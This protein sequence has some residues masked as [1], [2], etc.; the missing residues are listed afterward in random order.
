[1]NRKGNAMRLFATR[2]FIMGGMLFVSGW[3]GLTVPSWA[4]TQT[5]SFSNNITVDPSTG[6]ASAIIPLFTPEG[7]RGIAPS[8]N[9]SYSSLSGSGPFGNGWSMD[10]G[11]ITRSTRKGV[12]AYSPNDTFLC[13]LGGKIYE[14]VKVG[15]NEYRAR[16]E[17]DRLKFI[18]TGNYWVVQDPKGVSYFFGSR[19]GSNIENN[20]RVFKWRLDKVT[21][22]LNNLYVIDYHSDGSFEIRYV[23]KAGL[24]PAAADLN[25]TN[26]FAYVITSYVTPSNSYNYSVDYRPGFA[27]KEKNLITALTIRA[28][29]IRM[30]RY[31][32]S[33]SNSLTSGRSFLNSITEYASDNTT[34]RILFKISYTSQTSATY[35]VT[36]TKTSGDKLWNCQFGAGYD[37]GHENYGPVPGFDVDMGAVYTKASGTVP[38]GVSWSINNNGRLTFSSGQDEACQCWTYV[39]VNQAKTIP[40]SGTGG[41]EWGIYLNGSSV[42]NRTSLSLVAGYNLILVTD[43]HQHESFTF[44]LGFDLASKVDLM[45]STMSLVS[46]LAGD[47]NGDGRVDTAAFYP[48]TGN[49]KVALSSNSGFLPP[50]NWIGNFGINQKIVLGDF[51]G[52]GST[53]IAAYDIT[54][55][56]LRVAL[57]KPSSWSNAIRSFFDKGF[58]A[59]SLGQNADIATGDFNGDGYTDI[60]L[61]KTDESLKVQ[62]WINNRA[63]GFTAD[64]VQTLPYGDSSYAVMTGDFNADQMADIYAFKRSNGDWVVFENTDGHGRGSAFHVQSG[65]GTDRNPLL[66]DFN[67]DGRTDIAYYDWP[68]GK[69]T[70]RPSIRRGI[71]TVYFGPASDM[72]APFSLKDPNAQIQPG[73]YNGD[74]L[75]DAMAYIAGSNVTTELA[76]SSGPIPDL[77]K[78]L[79]NGR[80]AKTSVVYQPSTAFQQLNMPFVLPLVTE[81]AVSVLWKQGEVYRTSYSYSGGRWDPS[82]R[83]FMGFSRTTVKDAYGGRIETSFNTNGAN[84]YFRGRPVTVSNYDRYGK[85]L[86]RTNYHWYSKDWLPIYFRGNGFTDSSFIYLADIDKSLYDAGSSGRRTRKDFIYQWNT[87]EK[88]GDLVK[89]I[90]YGDVDF[91]TGNDIG[92]D[93]VTTALTYTN[94]ISFWILGLLQASVVTDQSGNYLSKDRFNYDANGLIIKNE[95]WNSLNKT[96]SWIA[97][98]FSYDEYGNLSGITD[99]LGHQTRYSMDS[100]YKLFVVSVENDLKHKVTR[101][102]YGVNESTSEGSGIFGQLKLIVDPNQ[103]KVWRTYDVWGR[104]LSLVSPLDSFAYPTRSW[105]YAQWTSY[106]VV[107]TKSRINHDQPGTL[108]SYTYYDGLGRVIMTK[109]KS[110]ENGKYVASGQVSYD[111][112]GAL[113]TSYQPFLT[114]LSLTFPDTVNSSRPGIKYTYDDQG[115]TVRINFPDGNY[116][117]RDY[118]SHGVTVIDANGHQERS[119]V[120]ARGRIIAREEYLGADGRSSYYPAEPYQLY[121]TTK[122]VYDSSGNL[123]QVIDAKGKITSMSYDTLGRK[124]A[125]NDQ[126]MHGMI[127][128]YDPLGQLKSQVDAKGVQVA[129]AFDSLGR[130]LVKTLSDSSFELVAYD[131]DTSP[132]FGRGRL[133]G[134]NYPSGKTIFTYNAVGDEISSSKIIGQDTY[135]VSRTYDALGRIISLTYPDGNGTAV[136]GYDASS[137]LLK[138]LKFQVMSGSVASTKDIITGIIYTANGN[139]AALNYGNGTTVVYSYDPLTSRLLRQVVKDPIGNIIQSKS[140]H[141]DPVGNVVKLSDDLKGLNMTFAYDALGRMVISNDNGI[142]VNYRYDETGNLL[143]K[144]RLVYTYGQNGSGPHAVTSL[145]DGT[146]MSYDPNG[147]LTVMTGLEKTQYFAYDADNRLVQVEFT[148]AGT[149]TRYPVASYAYDGDGGRTMKTVF[150]NKGASA[151][152]TTYVGELYEKS[153]GI[154]IDHLFLGGMRV[155]AFDGV[156][157]RWFIGDHLGS[158][159]LVLDEKSFVEEKVEF[160]PWG[161]IKNCEKYGTSPKV[162]WFYF[163]GKKIDA[164]AGL[165]FFGARYYNPKLGR[166][167]TADPTVQHPFDPQDLNRYSYCRNNPVSLVDP[168][169]YGWNWKSFLNSAAGAVVGVAL[170]IVLGPTGYGLSGWLAGALGGAA[171]GAT[172]AALNGA[173]GNGIIT[174][175]ALGGVLGCFGGWASGSH[176]MIGGFVLGSMF[177]GS[178][179]YAAQMDNWDSFAGGWAGAVIGWGMGDWIAKTNIEQF[180]NYRAGRGF[181]SDREL[182]FKQFAR[183]MNAR[184][185]LN[186]NRK[187]TTVDIVAR[188]LGKS[189]SGEPGSQSGPRHMAIVSSRLSHGSWEMGPE[190]GILRTTNT[191]IDLETWGTHL[192]TEKSITLAGDYIRRF[193]AEVN[194]AA[195]HENIQLYDMTFSGQTKYSALSFNSNFAVNSVI[196]GAGGEAPSRIRVYGYPDRP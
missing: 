98:D 149:V 94:D 179:A 56:S 157:L 141:Y 121:A 159:S 184:H 24:D 109:A 171:G 18:D 79:E 150:S 100:V 38:D 133:T 31:Q 127:Y 156:T 122:Y 160:T 112:R 165:V 25:S 14:L 30:R 185:A 187:D 195:L 114:T 130:P 90:D 111:A 64:P 69:I 134:V 49:V 136:Y 151:V 1:M 170:G 140:Y 83:E 142:V 193:S 74:G 178:V 183:E 61:K 68:N 103:Q 81:V 124:T 102:Y 26:N 181:Q 97:K 174:G 12:P 7:R 8:I 194:F 67:Q 70:F 152:T 23:L 58:W 110:D 10:L 166:F 148:D 101:E 17:E 59:S 3:I 91:N 52:D 138:T 36:T 84:V 45:N 5:Q 15:T 106:Y 57:S 180:S 154:E 73:D 82:A 19:P 128:E 161:E 144:G 188:P 186:V 22:R 145:S 78:S 95:T 27:V 51:N 176:N 62:I 89:T 42:V 6:G 80:G 87:T 125:M 155:A 93:R 43:Y 104:P 34:S 132:D 9:L 164:E 29:G 108:D 191:V 88:F 96:E 173:Q 175:A 71:I 99:A 46:N 177:A 162:A 153:D 2:N 126:D 172:T 192:C 33:Y 44:D 105:E 11:Y 60:L 77:L 139:I 113:E 169:G 53:D 76:Y 85:L 40:L 135:R 196:Y 63:N 137:G 92:D 129:F 13:S 147:N 65:F 189:A 55:G 28:N 35:S 66:A 4:D 117:T 168:S 50:Q 120:D 39:Y 116:E 16:V 167:I 72:P 131:Y 123:T 86:Q 21:D 115:R 146:S 163:T 75:T 41:G 32:F 37:R 143:Q 190:N 182:A 118:D 20:G 47:F 119:V 54:A 48:D 158:T 107:A